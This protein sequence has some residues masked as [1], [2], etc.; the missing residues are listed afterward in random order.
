MF[1]EPSKVI[2]QSQLFVFPST[3]EKT[4]LNCE[5][6][7]LSITCVIIPFC[8]FR[9]LWLK[10]PSRTWISFVYDVL[11]CDFLSLASFQQLPLSKSRSSIYSNFSISLSVRFLFLS[12]FLPS[13]LILFFSL[14]HVSFHYMVLLASV[15]SP[16]SAMLAT[17]KTLIFSHSIF[18]LV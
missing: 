7:N 12:H 14:L 1:I 10:L 11:C 4:L 13:S 9:N 18:P 17:P 3:G 15:F 5:N 8:L 2:F 16:N 6:S